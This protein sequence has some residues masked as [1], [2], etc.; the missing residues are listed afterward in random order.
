MA[1]AKKVL[2]TIPED[3]LARIDRETASIGSTRSEFL[4]EAARRQLGWPD[5]ST[6]D[7]ALERARAAL[8]EAGSFESADVIRADR[9]QRDKRDRGR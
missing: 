4:Q 6:L 8:A 7:E 3:L 2:V 1:K 9:D 5:P